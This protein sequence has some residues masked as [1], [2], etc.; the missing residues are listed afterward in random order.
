MKRKPRNANVE[1]IDMEWWNCCCLVRSDQYG[2]WH[3]NHF[4]WRDTV[5]ENQAKKAFV[6]LLHKRLRV[7]PGTPFRLSFHQY[8]TAPAKQCCLT[9]GRTHWN[10]IIWVSEVLGVCF[11]D[12]GV[13][14]AILRLLFVPPPSR[15]SRRTPSHNNR[16]IS[17]TM[18]SDRQS[19]C[20]AYMLEIPLV[21]MIEIGVNLPCKYIRTLPARRKPTLTT[22]ANLHDGSQPSRRNQP[23]RRKPTFTTDSYTTISTPHKPL[24]YNTT[25]LSTTFYC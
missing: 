15:P 20:C 2:T 24:K 4:T 16:R 11:M 25:P 14:L 19:I 21:F 8:E 13:I 6:V 1:S 12:I 10:N 9:W 18:S 23:S 5:N 7:P 17:F 3:V 22:D